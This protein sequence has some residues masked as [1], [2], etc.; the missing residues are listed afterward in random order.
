MNGI[1]HVLEVD[2]DNLRM[3]EFVKRKLGSFESAKAFYE[4]IRK[5]EDL[6]CCRKVIHMQDKVSKA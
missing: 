4:F 6:P 5:E 3:S 2:E 1:F